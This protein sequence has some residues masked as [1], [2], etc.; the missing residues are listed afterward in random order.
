[1]ETSPAVGCSNPA[2]SRRQVGLPEPDGPS[3]AKN[4]PSAISKLTSSTA[5][6]VPKWRLTR[7]NRTAG[8]VSAKAA[9]VAIRPGKAGQAGDGAL[10]RA[11][12]LAHRVAVRR[13]R[14]RRGLLVGVAGRVL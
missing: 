3:M 4:S 6:T 1:M 9:F 10:V 8:I 12:T 2:I 11:G 7:S 13:L 14:C 5:R